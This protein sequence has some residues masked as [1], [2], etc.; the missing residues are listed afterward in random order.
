MATIFSSNVL[1]NK[2]KNTGK[3]IVTCSCMSLFTLSPVC[4]W[5]PMQA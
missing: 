1:K 2:K 5:L 4:Q 3:D